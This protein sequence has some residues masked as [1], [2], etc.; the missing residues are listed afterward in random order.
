MIYDELI[1]TLNLQHALLVELI[2]LTS[3]RIERDGDSTGLEQRKLDSY[4]KQALELETKIKL[5]D[6]RNLLYGEL[7]YQQADLG[8]EV[9]M[10][11]FKILHAVL[12][13]EDTSAFV[14]R[15]QA[16]Y[17]EFKRIDQKIS[18]IE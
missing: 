16:I 5:A 10:L 4:R 9:L 12:A 7:L 6:E 1:A 15:K 2:G 13:G 3:L 17:D 14:E 18:S 11:D 8:N